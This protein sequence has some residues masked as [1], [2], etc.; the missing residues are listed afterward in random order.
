MFELGK[1]IKKERLKQK[2]TLKQLSDATNISTSALWC[3]ENNKHK[4]VSSVFLLRISKVLKIDYNELLRCRWDI[5]PIFLNGGKFTY[6][7][8]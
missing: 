8:K 2:L 6:G 5:F 4:K 1:M 7:S 3:I